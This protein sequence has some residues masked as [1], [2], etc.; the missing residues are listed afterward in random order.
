MKSETKFA[1]VTTPT[2]R[3]LIRWDNEI[4]RI[5][6]YCAACRPKEDGTPQG[7]YSMAP[8]HVTDL[9]G[10]WAGTYS[11]NSLATRIT[12]AEMLKIAALQTADTHS[13]SQKMNWAMDGGNNTWGQL[14]QA[15]YNGGGDWQNAT[16]IRM[17]A[18]VWAG[19]WVEV[20]ERAEFITTLNDKREMTPMSR[21]RTYQPDEWHL[22]FATQLVTSVS[23]R[24]VYSEQPKGRFWW[25]I[26]FGNREA[27]VFDRWLEP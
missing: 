20:V 14:M 11:E 6:G 17:I 3:Q 16:D 25:P 18:A 8:V 23:D 4:A 15:T 5:D 21:I 22:P 9:A 26:Y 2:R 1:T 10:N 27:W 7:Q 13:V 24:N 12:N 19:Q